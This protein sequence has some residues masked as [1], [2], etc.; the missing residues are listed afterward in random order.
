[1]GA[2]RRYPVTVA[3]K[4]GVFAVEFSD[5]GLARLDFN[6]NRSSTATRLPHNLDRQLRDYAAGKLTRFRV[7]LDLSSGTPFQRAV[8]RAMLTIP[9]GET[10]SYRWIARKIGRPRATRAVGAACGANPVAV[11]VPCHRV[12]AG[13][14]SIG[15]FGGGLA[16]K[17]KLLRLEGVKL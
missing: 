17:R 7:P 3:T 4:L 9:L 16:W 12:I 15:G 8:W 13:D 5:R 6:A 11:V 2:V 1:M 10:R 14:G